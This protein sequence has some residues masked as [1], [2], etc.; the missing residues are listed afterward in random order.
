[1]SLAK[2]AEQLHLP[3]PDQTE[4][5]C[6][7]LGR[8]PSEFLDVEACLSGSE[9]PEEGDDSLEEEYESDF[10]SMTQSQAALPDQY[11]SARNAK[12]TAICIP[13]RFNLQ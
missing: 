11:G 10:V 3:N 8:I 7:L 13:C 5:V 6:L 1:M 9:D 12:R 2:H 4:A